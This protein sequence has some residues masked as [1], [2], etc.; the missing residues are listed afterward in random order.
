MG[1]ILACNS[2]ELYHR[3]ARMVR[4]WEGEITSGGLDTKDV[5]AL[6][7]G[8]LDSLDDEYIKMRIEQTQDFGRK[9]IAAGVPIVVPPGSHA[10]FLDARRFLPHVDQEQYPAQA[11]AAALY[12]ETGVRAMERGNV[13]KGR[14]PA[15]G[16]NYRPKL[17]LVRCTIPRR[18]YTGSHIDYV[19]DGIAR[20]WQKRE[21]LTGLRFVYEPKLLRFFQGRFEPLGRWEL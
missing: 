2:A 21:R 16:Q 20:L 3:F 12:I 14:D 13:S 5:V 4:T 18:V 19:V 7:R 1:G 6:T 11:L 10:I 8:L 9:L 15:T 17:E